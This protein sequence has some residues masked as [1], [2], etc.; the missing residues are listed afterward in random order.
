MNC[1]CKRLLFVWLIRPFLFGLI[2]VSTALAQTPADR[3]FTAEQLRSDFQLMRRALEEAHP[4]LYRYQTKD[5]ANRAFDAIAAKLNRDMTESEFRQVIHPAVTRIGCGHTSLEY[6]KAFAKWRKK[7]L[8]KPLPITTFLAADNR[9]FITINNSTSAIAAPGS[10]ILQ[11][12]GQ[13]IRGIQEQIYSHVSSDGYNETF[14]RLVANLRFDKYFRYVTGY[15]GDSLTVT[16]RD[17]SGV[18][19][20]AL[21]RLKLVKKPKKDTTATPKPGEKLTKTPKPKKRTLTFSERDSSVAVLT[22][23]TFSGGGQRGFFRRSFRA[24][25]GQ[26]RIKTLVLDL[27]TNGGGSSDA[28]VR[29]LRYLI[30]HPFQPYA[31]GDAPLRNV[32]F[33]KYLNQRFDRFVGR[34]VANVKTPQG[35]YR[36][37]GVGKMYQPMAGTGFRGKISVLTSGNTFSAGAIT[38]SL[39]QLNERER[40]TFIGR[41]T[42]G[43]RYGCS[44]FVT[45]FLRLPETGVRL[46]FPLYKISLPVAGPDEGRGVMPDFPVDYTIQQVL[47]KTDLDMDK[48]LELAKS[49]H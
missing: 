47:K 23:N 24:L 11:L 17:S 20:D 25:A 2:G 49:T 48:A 9:L 10:E 35:T 13:P 8:A 12:N 30:A 38:A 37:R 6:S 28:C 31:E 4:G 29:L 36:R 18:V 41:E 33:N 34:L 16:L 15:E 7:H 43:G 40:T 32:S 5:S 26:P 1:T 39:L 3:V 27:R 14:K 42:G 46:R 45:P 19:Q 22:L 21:L 44:A